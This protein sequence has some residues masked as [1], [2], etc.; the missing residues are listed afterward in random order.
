VEIEVSDTPQ[1]P[2]PQTQRQRWIKYGANVT[3]SSLVVI[4]LAII[5]TVIAQ[6]SARRI[7][8]TIGASQSLRP[9]TLNYI[10]NDLKTDV[11]IVALYPKLKN[12]SH[13]QDFY[14]PV[15]DLLN[16]YATKGRH[17]TVQMIDPDTQKDDVNKLVT[18]V[19]NRFGGE[20]KGYKALLND[21]PA[22]NDILRKFAADEAA[23]YRRL[24]GDQVHDQN[25]QQALYIAYPTLLAIPK[26]LTR[27]SAAVDADVNQQIPS[28]KEAV[29]E[30]RTSY[31]GIS[32]AMDLFTGLLDQVKGA[33]NVPKEIVDYVPAAE[34]R[35]ADAKKVITA[36]LDRISK[37]G[38]LKELDEFRDQLR[39]KSIIVMTDSGYRIIQ[40]EQAWKVPAGSVFGAADTDVSP[41][42]IFSGEQQISGAIF[43]LTEQKP[44]VVFLRPGG[45]PITSTMNGGQAIFSAVA[46]RLRDYNFDVREKD[47]S[48]QSAM[49]GN[50]PTAPELN[51]AVWIIVRDP[52]NTMPEDEVPVSAMLQKHLDQGG[53]AFV[54]MFPTVDPTIG[55]LHSMG[56][57]VNTDDVIVHEALPST[58]RRSND[59]VDAALQSSQ[60][61]YLLDEYGDHPIA[62]PL[63]GLDFVNAASC[64]VAILPT[65]PPGVTATGLLPIPFTPHSWAASGGMAVLQSQGQRLT[66]NPEPDPA[67]G[68]TTGDVD[69]TPEHQLYGGAASENA[70]GGRLVVVGSYWFASSEP[71]D[72]PDIDMLEKH[73]VSVARLPGNG[74]FFVDSVFWL[75][76][77]DDMLA[78]SPHALQVARVKNMSPGKLGFWRLGV[79]TAGLPLAVIFAGLMVY[80]R[81]RD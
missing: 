15:A 18:E 10:Q 42:L 74:E 5:V 7:D 77:M 56:I 48:G 80:V 36:M 63:D 14:Q 37:L 81:R 16:D 32:Q 35:A 20:V 3:V 68:R 46:A 44:M 65:Q 13:E 12:E 59:M 69:N 73:G 4:A 19:T 79:L 40:F 53:S 31:T 34:S 50:E 25:L 57:N 24:P 1:Q 2:A 54:L 41:R 33:Q 71:V 62:K 22:Q 23:L 67:S 45:P 47:L 30:V 78:I 76:H 8:T 26:E 75:S 38:A 55:P 58:G 43:A 11:Q 66:F 6:G 70:A 60:F 21:V 39:S 51:S 64:P 28:Y 9:Q 72:L 29:D 52:Q 61:F 17:I 49:M 27:L